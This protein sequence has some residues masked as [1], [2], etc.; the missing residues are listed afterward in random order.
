MHK[1][2]TNFIGIFKKVPAGAKVPDSTAIV[3][4]HFND[5]W[6][7]HRESKVAKQDIGG[8]I[9]QMNLKKCFENNYVTG[10]LFVTRNHVDWD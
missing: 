7:P 10:T 2:S 3:L 8:R 1:S 5:V 4:Y 9:Y 6:G